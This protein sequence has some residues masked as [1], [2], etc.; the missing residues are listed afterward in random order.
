MQICRAIL[1]P[2]FFKFIF[3]NSRKR[4]YS[5]SKLKPRRKAYQRRAC[6]KSFCMPVWCQNQ[7][8]EEKQRQSRSRSASNRRQ[9]CGRHQCKF[10]LK[11]IKIK[12]S[13]ITDYIRN[14]VLRRDISP[15]LVY[16]LR[17]SSR[18]S[19]A[20]PVHAVVHDVLNER[21]PVARLNFFDAHGPGSRVLSSEK[22]YLIEFISLILPSPTPR[23]KLQF[24]FVSSRFLSYCFLL[25]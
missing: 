11:M 7:L 21:H 3:L 9:H 6:N 13:G 5:G 20:V 19:W 15:L 23:I 25:L 16:F 8:R 14:R 22:L 10:E 1:N 18:V 12:Y 17:K 24:R 4:I 2:Y